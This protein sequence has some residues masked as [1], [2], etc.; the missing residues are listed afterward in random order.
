MDAPSTLGGCFSATTFGVERS[1]GGAIETSQP[2][3]V[4]APV[5]A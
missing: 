3:R 5:R 1:A 4:L 2:A